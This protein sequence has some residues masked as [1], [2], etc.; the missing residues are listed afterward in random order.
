[1]AGFHTLDQQITG[2]QHQFAGLAALALQPQ[3]GVAAQ[4]ALGEIHLQIQQQM[5]GEEIPGV[6]LRVRISHRAVRLVALVAAAGTG[7]GLDR[8]GQRA[9]HQQ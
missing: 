8:L 7:A 2:V 3:F 9:A 4:L 6:G 5:R 1:M